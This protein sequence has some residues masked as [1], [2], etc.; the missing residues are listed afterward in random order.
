MRVA[1]HIS[2][3]KKQ[4]TKLERWSQGRTLSVRQSERARI[5]L[6]AADGM[7]NK[8]IAIEMGVTRRARHRNVIYSMWLRRLL[9]S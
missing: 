6:L 3:T 5:V 9:C 2:L 1:V 8:E 7:P 4:R